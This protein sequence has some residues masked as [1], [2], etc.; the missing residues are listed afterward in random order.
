[1]FNGGWDE[2]G[3]P[4]PFVRGSH[5]NCLHLVSSSFPGV[6]QNLFA[7]RQI[8]GVLH[9]LPLSSLIKSIAH[10]FIHQFVYG[11]RIRHLVCF[12]WNLKQNMMFEARHNGR[13]EHRAG[14]TIFTQHKEAGRARGFGAQVDAEMK[15]L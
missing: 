1:M 4:Q 10:L 15:D 6:H 2:C 9:P 7:D 12:F 11:A 13:H 5:K 8:I 14:G 3:N